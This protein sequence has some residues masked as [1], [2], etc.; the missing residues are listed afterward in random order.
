MS[1]EAD[2]TREKE[3]SAKKGF[4]LSCN[5]E[6]FISRISDGMY[7]RRFCEIFSSLKLIKRHISG[8]IYVN[9]FPRRLNTVRFSNLK[10]SGGRSRMLFPKR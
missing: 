8:G 6:S 1:R 7:G 3:G 4:G 10:S 2:G 5:F 9:W